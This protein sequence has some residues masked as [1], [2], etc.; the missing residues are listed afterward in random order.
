MSPEDEAPD[1]AGLNDHGST[2]GERR[3]EAEQDDTSAGLAMDVSAART[4]QDDD[5]A[6]RPLPDRLVTELTAHRTLALRNALAEHPHVALTALLHTLVK[7]RFQRRADKGVLAARIHPVF[8]AVQDAALKDASSARAIEDRHRGW[9]GDVPVEDEALWDW[10][11]GLEEARRLAL[12][13]HCIS[14]GV[15][16]LFEKPS[17][18]GG[19]GLS[20]RELKDRLAEADRLARA[21]DLDM[22]KAGWRP[23]IGNYLGQ[24]SKLRILVAVREGVGEQA[25]QRIS[26][27]KKLDMAKEAEQLLRDSGWLPEPLR[28][29]SAGHAS[30][31]L[32]PA[33]DGDREIGRQSFVSEA[34][35]NR[36][37]DD[38]DGERGLAIAAE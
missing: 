29:A 21:T 38:E 6:I 14:F 22:V 3:E 8:L 1:P 30:G 2:G 11:T 36:A 19:R 37:I 13:A 35:V 32:K 16:A 12:L 17:R 34:D 4:D 27:L 7:D 33:R 23:T 28:H 26:H 18:Y 15:N 9:A 31:P 5:D 24:V 20:Q 25:A 10:L